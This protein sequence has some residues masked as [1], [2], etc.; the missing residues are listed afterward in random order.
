MADLDFIEICRRKIPQLKK[1]FKNREIYIWGAA[2]G[3]RIV[4]TVMKECGMR[5]DGFIDK[6]ADVIS[7]YLGYP[8]K[9]ADEMNPARHY[10]IVSI[11]YINF[12]ILK[13]LEELGYTHLDCYYLLENEGFHK[14]DFIYRGCRIG[15]YTYGYE[16][17]L[18]Y[19]PI[20]SE[21]GRY[22]S[23]NRT[24]RIWNNHPIDYISTHPML[25]HLSFY[26]WSQWDVRKEMISRYGKYYSNAEYED[27]PLRNNKSV[28]IGNDVWIGGNVVILPG[29][30]IGN[31]AVLAAGAVITKDVPPYAVTAGVPA[32]V[33]RY[34]FSADLIAK[35]EEI[36][37][38]NWSIE[39]IENN[40]EL[41]YQPEA[42]CRKMQ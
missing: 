13:A 22:C 8:V 34:R 25:D 11:T 19:F 18:E 29:V 9:Q 38:W 32:H 26:E 27:S 7:E 39:Q 20:A 23:I 36:Q 2:E 5:P 1:Y 42:F 16:Q 12:E 14:E 17:L 37:W 40:I 33:I 31:G 3:G 10:I 6:R 30:R 41:F 15:R 21:I 35:L 28:S 4:E 24:A